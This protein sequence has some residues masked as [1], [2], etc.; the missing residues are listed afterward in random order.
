[1]QC[2]TVHEWFS[3]YLDHAL[4]AADRAG[5]AEHLAVCADC[6]EQLAGL[7]RVI[8]ALGTLEAPHAPDLMPGIQAKLAARRSLLGRFAERFTAPWPISLP[9]HGV[10]LAATALLVIMVSRVPAG[11]EEQPLAQA[12]ASLA[13]GNAPAFMNHEEMA[14]NSEQAG[15][16]AGTAVPALESEPAD[17]PVDLAARQ[18]VFERKSAAGPYEREADRSAA[19]VMADKAFA[20]SEE[21]AVSPVWLAT[22]VA[23]HHGYL[24]TLRP[25]RLIIK[26]PASALPEFLRRFAAEQATVQYL[27]ADPEWVALVLERMT[28]D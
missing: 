1:M 9:L 13:R 17:E 24:L 2:A 28:A 18:R 12:P 4:P 11:K 22:W 15:I 25:G 26:L 16:S 23:D 5:M 3:L 21:T 6:R 7:S 19:T 8:H 10:A 14:A 20:P 27:T